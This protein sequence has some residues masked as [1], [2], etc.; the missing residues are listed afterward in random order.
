MEQKQLRYFRQILGLITIVVLV[1]SAY[2]S[3]K[4]FAY[5]MNWET[6]SSQTYSEYMRYLIYM[7][8]LLTSAFIFYETFRRRENRAQ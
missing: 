7:L 3:Y 1:I 4:V 6:G 8:F 5:I 2:Y